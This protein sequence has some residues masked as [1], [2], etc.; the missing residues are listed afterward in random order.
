MT[1]VGHI[2]IVAPVSYAL[3]LSVPLTILGA[4]LPDLIDKPLWAFGIGAP[5]F[6][7][8]TLLF[9]ILVS[10]PFFVWKRRYGISML[11]GISSHLFLD[12]VTGG[13]PIPW[14]YPFRDY[15][16]VQFIFDPS[17]FVPRMIAMFEHNFITRTGLLELLWVALS[18]AAICLLVR[19]YPHV[20]T[21]IRRIQS[22]GQ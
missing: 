5:R 20:K 3:K 12:W 18:V 9:I 21:L 13:A 8:H 7:A 10:I 15:P 19:L 22:S 14:L 4:I 17:L 2:G 6:A 16:Y 11:L 1:F